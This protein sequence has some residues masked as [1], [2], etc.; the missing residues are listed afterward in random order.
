MLF[1]KRLYNEAEGGERMRDLMRREEDVAPA[2]AVGAPTSAKPALDSSGKQTNEKTPLVSETIL[3]QLYTESSSPQPTHSDEG[4]DYENNQETEIPH[5]DNEIYMHQIRIFLKV[6]FG[7][8]TI[9]QYDNDKPVS[10]C[11]FIDNTPGFV[12]SLLFTRLRGQN[13]TSTT[14]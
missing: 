11:T 8:I 5:Y 6:L 2:S 3:T 14:R 10:D 1:L 7:L 12:E 9:P 13:P 4:S